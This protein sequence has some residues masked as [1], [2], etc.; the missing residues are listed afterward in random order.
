MKN[1]TNKT[2]VT[3]APKTSSA[4]RV[5]GGN[6]HNLSAQEREDLTHAETVIAHHFDT[7]KEAGTALRDVRE[8]RLYRETH[9]TF[10]DYCRARWEMSKT[11]ANRLI[12]SASVVEHV[13]EIAGAAVVQSLTESAIRPLTG[14]T[15]SQQKQIFKRVLE[16]A[17]AK[18]GEVPGRGITAKLVQ[19]V[20]KATY[21]KAFKKAKVPRKTTP[22][23]LIR[24]SEFLE[25]LSRWESERRT[26]GNFAAIPP[27][28]V[29]TA[30]RKIV[31]HL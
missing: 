14:L 28:E 20:A 5:D 10:E 29:L 11:Q 13:A 16:Q 4:T 22:P 24:R 7:F 18:P 2:K 23:D 6:G 25:E 17:P 21:P 19:Q 30:V 12:A 1:I 9:A 3:T 15:P 31:E 26:E 8:R 27:A